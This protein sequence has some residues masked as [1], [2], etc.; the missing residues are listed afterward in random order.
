MI[1]FT[2]FNQDSAI[3]SLGIPTRNSIPPRLQVT[4]SA[5]KSS[6]KVG[7]LITFHGSAKGSPIEPTYRWDFD[8]SDGIDV[9][10]FAANPT[11]VFG[12]PGNYIVTLTVQGLDGSF[13]QKTLRMKISQRNYVKHEAIVNS[14]CHGTEADPIVIEGFEISSKFGNGIELIDCSWV[15]IRNNYIHDI[16]VQDIDTYVDGHAISATRVSHLV[17]E[18]NII[19]DNFRGI[20]INATPKDEDEQDIRITGNRVEGSTA[21]H[22]I[23]I[24]KA[25]Q[26]VVNGNISLNNGTAA[27]FQNYR[28]N[29]V[30]LWDCQHAK[31]FDNLAI[32][33]STDGFGASRTIVIPDYKNTPTTDI[34]FSR[35]VARQ[36][37]EQGIW[38]R[39]VDHALVSDNYIADNAKVVGMHPANGI[40]FEDGVNNSEVVGNYSSNNVYNE[41]EIWGSKDVDV[42]ANV[43]QPKTD[44]GIGVEGGIEAD[45]NTKLYTSN[46]HVHNNIIRG[47]TYG[48]QIGDT[49]GVTVTG[50]SVLASSEVGIQ[51][52]DKALNSLVAGNIVYGSAGDS[53]LVTLHSELAPNIQWLNMISQSNKWFSKLDP[54]FMN[55]NLGD[56]R[57]MNNSPALKFA[58]LRY[59]R[60]SIG[61]KFAPAGAWCGNVL[62]RE[63]W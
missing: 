18:G 22:A 21:N 39:L 12:K 49:N 16:G 30:A 17:I 1:L 57:L 28:V 27:L 34:S 42:H 6:A 19:T 46:V 47:G 7:E 33:N 51:V 8:A 2:S 44:V 35:N 3:S 11:Y 62:S 25:S 58:D 4:V 37:G 14:N 36:N 41:I 31:V 54:K 20:W 60:C 13:G 38:L 52:S 50:N 29:G 32:G 55:Y 56:S 48:I 9:D 24:W 45:T 61:F 43:L 10:K 59:I 26:V 53:Y 5:D 15:V 40:F 63:P 23:S